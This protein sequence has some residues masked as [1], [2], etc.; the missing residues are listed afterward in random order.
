MKNRWRR[1]A[2]L[3]LCGV[4]LWLLRDVQ[5]VRT[6]AARALSLCAGTV[7]PS[8]F[9]FLVISGLLIA[10]GF[11]EWLAPHF[12]GL[13]TPLFRLPGQASGPLLLGLV[14]GY[15]IGAQSAAERTE[16]TTAAGRDTVRQETARTFSLRAGALPPRNRRPVSRAESR[17]MSH[18][19]TPART[20]PNTP[21]PRTLM[22]KM[23]LELL[24]KASSRS[25]SP[26]EHKPFSYRPMAVLAPTG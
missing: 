25:A 3:V 9:P 2:C 13:M 21:L 11:G 7:I 15:P 6:A 12:S 10:L 4:L 24:Q 23:G 8:L 1:D 26:L 20:L 17:W 16:D 18:S 22:R 5:H 14:G 19:H